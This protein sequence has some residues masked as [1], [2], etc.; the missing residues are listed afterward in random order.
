MSLAAGRFAPS[1]T[2]RIHAGNIFAYLM[3][4][5]Q[6]RSQGGTMVLRIEDLDVE[7]SKPRFADL[8]QRDL[9]LLGL[10]WDSG[11]FYQN[12]RREA[13]EEAFE[14]IAQ[15]TR[16]YPCFCT[17]ADLAAVSAPHLGEKAVYP[18]TCRSL[19][20][21]S[22]EERIQAGKDAAWRVE[23]PP[24]RIGFEDGL[25]GSYSQLLSEDCGDFILRRKDGAFAYQLAVVVDD[26]A[27]GITS[28]T[29]G[30]DLLSSTP[31]QMFLQDLL[32]F[33]HPEYLHIPLLV[34]RS[35]RRLSKRDG[36]A[37]LDEMLIRFET[38][39][40]IIGHIAYLAGLQPEDAPVTPEELVAAYDREALQ[41]RLQGRIAIPWT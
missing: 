27:Q 37:S 8:I 30:I 34:N 10:T 15:Q 12:G 22:A 24:V 23:A 26:A 25:Q 19:S 36:D 16:I 40:G 39:Q 11:P 3:A 41:K 21:A 2:G 9:E 5:L 31:Q 29:R 17:R 33:P 14:R 35:G 1:P 7:R 4:W 20:T 18:G 38:P 6:V 32:G 28:V 13:Y